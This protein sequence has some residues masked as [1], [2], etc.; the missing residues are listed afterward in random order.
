MRRALMLVFWTTISACSSRDLAWVAPPSIAGFTASARTI[1]LGESTSLAAV[2][3]GGEGFVDPGVSAVSSGGSYT[4]SPQRDTIYTLRV[5][6]AAGTTV[7]AELPVHVERAP[8]A[9]ATFTYS[10]QPAEFGE[11]TT[12]SWTLE[13]TA[14]G[15]TLNGNS[16]LGQSSFTLSPV[17]RE[18]HVLFASNPLGEE[19]RTLS[20]AARG[21]NLFAGSIGGRGSAD[22]LRTN[23][24]FNNP[25]GVAV[26]G[27]GNFFVAD[28]DNH[29]IRKVT[30]D[31][32]VSTF[33]GV[34]GVPGA[35]DGVGSEALFRAP[36]GVAVDRSGN[37]YVADTGNH[38]IRAIGADG[39]VITFAGQA[40]TV[41]SDNGFRLEA[42]FRSP[43]GVGVDRI[44]NVYV[45]DTYNHTIR[46]IGGDGMVTTLAGDPGSIGSDNGQGS[47]ARFNY[48][49][50]V[51]ISLAGNV[52][53]ADTSNHTVRSIT[54]DNTVRTLAG[55]PGRAGNENGSGAAARFRS[56][57]AVTVDDQG[58]LFVAD[59]DNRILRRVTEAG[60]VSTLAG[61]GQI[62]AVDGIARYSRFYQPRGVTSDAVG[63][64]YVA[65][66]GNHTVRKISFDGSVSTLAGLA[67]GFSG[68]FDGPGPEARFNRPRG[69]AMDGSGN[70]YIVDRLTVRRVT[71]AGVVQTLAGSATP[72][73]ADGTFG[74][75][76]F[77]QLAGVTV[78]AG[79]DGYVAESRM[80]TLRKV[81]LAG[82]VTTVAG[83]VGIA[84][85]NDGFGT[86]AHF[87]MP[88]GVAADSFGN[89]FIADTANHT[90]RKMS[91]DRFVTT[92]AGR[93]GVSGF[94]DGAGAEARFYFPE[95]LAVDISGN[96]YVADTANHTIRVLTLDGSVITLAGLGGDSRKR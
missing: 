75:A 1:F 95:G 29:T 9:I 76:R 28:T 18:R 82:V 39:A 47:S 58:N 36:R 67:G 61:S 4:V 57:Q 45:A 90:I 35:A 11:T 59:T 96:V 87:N 38:T 63:N 79:G 62:G 53:V 68:T 10:P 52:Y 19:S 46:K 56:P 15:L 6:N 92:V 88:H 25:H 5:T 89:V 83:E 13:G 31:G 8:V 72:G 77:D 48:P 50:G 22:G 65:D 66:S 49:S 34:A 27:S 12:L 43:R 69:L 80:H 70:A 16:V 26:D 30:P 2:F 33:A 44:G 54:P 17:R 37:V 24:R 74:A 3:E 20:V 23:A 64:V 21:L 42:R 84:G 40:N 60:E 41:G 91:P 93:A 71:P 51:A 78:G 86:G 7:T 14:T 85:S 55:Y 32:R 73:T 81:T 94:V